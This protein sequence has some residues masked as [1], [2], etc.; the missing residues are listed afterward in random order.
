MP[1]LL[2]LDRLSLAAPD[3]RA[4]FSDL[5]I[6]IDRE[7]VAFV[8][9]NGAGKSTL[10]RAILGEVRPL[11]G[12]IAT[13]GRIGML[14]QAT[15]DAEATAADALGVRAPLAR[16]DR[17]ERG[18]GT[19]DD[20]NAADWLLPGRI[21]AAL[22]DVGLVGVDLDRPLGGFSG[23]ER[24]RLGLAR[25]LV[26]APDLILLD[27]PTNDLD[28]DGRR[29]VAALVRRWRGGIVIASHDRALL[30]EVDRI[31]ELSPVRI[32][33]VGG[34]WSA[35]AAA[36]DAER[37]RAATAVKR[38]EETLRNA[39]QD[40][41][42]ARERQAR[43]DAGGRAFA[44]SG[45]DSRLSL[46]LAKRRAESTAGRS[47]GSS[48]RRIDEAEDALAD[49]AQRIEVTAPLSIE[50]PLTGL[51]ASRTVLSLDEVVLTRGG[52]RLFGPLTLVLRGPARVA[53]A[54]RNG[55]GKSSLLKLI[56]GDLEP[57]AGTVL[58]GG[59]VACLDQHVGLLD[60]RLS[61]LDNIRRHHPAM[62]D[63]EAH[64]AL[65]RFAFRNRDALKTAASLSGG[66]R[67]RAGL[68]CVMSGLEPP[69]LLLLDEPTNHLDLAAIEVLER[70]LRGFDG[71]LVVVSHDE[72]FLEAIGID[73]TV[74]LPG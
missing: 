39:R 2:T 11:S 45:G 59:R 4:L 6:S 66:E 53:V 14:R 20:L 74:E 9:R 64:A 71:A 31:V 46:G 32:F 57:S 48:A 24:M 42:T 13:G 34:G 41:Q 38:A 1:A 5:T 33:H 7:R 16:L 56:A 8:G 67:L 73:R 35:F 21:E 12:S 30:E 69:Q 40:A 27:E 54:G 17:I 44:A 43:R 68:A 65:A 52:R 10:L 22:A 51:P 3:G 15:I 28:R 19:A 36:R 70:A 26:D 49:A 18:A 55:A 61:L 72:A 50:L 47:A 58:R 60:D 37:D 25:L 62:T 23:G 29:A 63:N